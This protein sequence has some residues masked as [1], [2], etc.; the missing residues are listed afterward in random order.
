[1]SDEYTDTA[2]VAEVIDGY[3]FVINKGSTDEVQVGENFLIFRLGET[4]SD[5]DTGEH[6]GALEI[7]V[8]RA[9]VVHVQARISTLESNEKKTIP[10]KTR[11]IRRQ[12]SWPSFSG[13]REEEIEEG[14]K[15]RRM[16]IDVQ[17][18]DMARPI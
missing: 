14:A 3:K 17:V 7:V 9:K 10:G 12:S 13:P 8:G 5:P 6:L 16:T 1:M 11:T 15:T 18:G 2:K 4:I